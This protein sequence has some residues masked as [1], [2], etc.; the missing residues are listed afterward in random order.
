M[1]DGAVV[2]NGGLSWPVACWRSA[3]INVL[4]PA[5]SPFY[6]PVPANAFVDYTMESLGTEAGYSIGDKVRLQ[7]TV[8]A[9]ANSFFH[10]I[11]DAATKTVRMVAGS[12]SNAFYVGH[13]TTGTGTGLTTGGWD[14]RIHAAWP[15][16]PLGAITPIADRREGQH[17]KSGGARRIL[18][19]RLETPWVRGKVGRVVYDLKN[20]GH[21]DEPMFVQL[22]AR[23]VEPDLGYSTGDELQIRGEDGAAAGGAGEVHYNGNSVAYTVAGGWVV[24]PNG[25]TASAKITV[26]KWDFQLRM[27]FAGEPD[28]R[29]DPRAVMIRNGGLIRMW[30]SPWKEIGIQQIPFVMPENF[31][32]IDIGIAIRCRRVVGTSLFQPGDQQLTGHAGYSSY[33]GF[34]TIHVAGRVATM[35]SNGD[36]VNIFKS[37][38]GAGNYMNAVPGGFELQLRAIG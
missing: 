23:C 26:T 13:K 11:W 29:F 37:G 38:A 32:P 25:L 15:L 8:I 30:H 14:Q 18:R 21:S 12:A 34:N 36:T 24:V 19:K 33:K 27:A 4:S 28:D 17:S 10:L 1:R 5:G 22:W 20:Y 2:R 7:R 35:K 3:L 9:G 6:G 31:R 16:M